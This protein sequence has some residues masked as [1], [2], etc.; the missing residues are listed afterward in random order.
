[1]LFSRLI[2]RFIISKD[3]KIPNPKKVQAIMNMP[4]FTNPRHIE[5]FNGIA[6]FYRCF[7][8]NFAFIVALITKLMKKMELFIWTVEC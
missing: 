2:L 4:V 7:I 1:M 5:V 3:E 6:Q 8:E